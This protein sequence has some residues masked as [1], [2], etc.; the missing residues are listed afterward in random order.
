MNK[1]LLLGCGALSSQLLSSL[2]PDLRGKS[3]LTILDFDIIEE[4]NLMGTQLFFPEQK[5]VKKTEALQYNIYK[6]FNR[7]VEII[8]E[9]LSG[10][11]INIL[12]DYDLIIDTFDNYLSRKLV[13]NFVVK[14]KIDCLHCGFSE[15]L[16]F[17][18]CWAENYNVPSDTISSFDVCEAE[19]ASSFI[20]LTSACGA[21]AVLAFINNGEKRNFIGNRFLVK[22][23]L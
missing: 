20:K 9:K 22:E 15:K 17:E 7:K 8:T 21:N 10:D 1:I 18:I 5:G 12:K 19:G 11:N 13:Q 14:N 2:A 23:I 3:E 16:T 4:R 6:L